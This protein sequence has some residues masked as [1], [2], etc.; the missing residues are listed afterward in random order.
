[1]MLTR[2]QLTAPVPPPEED[3]PLPELGN[4]TYVRVRGFTVAQ[5][6]RFEESIQAGN[7]KTVKGVKE[8]LVVA[9]CR[10]EA[11]EPLFKPED[12]AALSQQ[13]AV[14][15]ERIVTTAM[16]LSGIGEVDIPELKKSS[17][18]TQGD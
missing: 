13:P 16:R 11:G 5:R 10:D 4:G 2:E 7:G 15:I 9:C 8:R 6:L 18:E 14:V 1:M 17:D 12:V 3:V